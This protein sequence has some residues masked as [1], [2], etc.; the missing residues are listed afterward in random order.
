[1]VDS[2]TTKLVQGAY[3]APPHRVYTRAKWTD[4]WTLR[5]YLYCNWCQSDCS[6]TL[7]R[8]ELRYQYGQILRPG[9]IKYQEFAALDVNR[10]FVKIEIDLPEDDEEEDPQFAK[11]YGRIWDVE[12]EREGIVSGYI[13]GNLKQTPMGSQRFSCLGL[14]YELDRLWLSSSVLD[15]PGDVDK[16]GEVRINRAIDVNRGGGNPW[17]NDL[18][19]LPNRSADIGAKNFYVFSASIPR[20]KLWH[21]DQFLE[22]L[23]AYHTPGEIPWSVDP[24]GQLGF[25]RWWEPALELH[26]LTIRQVIDV[27]VDRRRLSTWFAR[28]HEVE[29]DVDQVKIYVASLTPNNIT[30]DLDGQIL[31]R[32]PYQKSIDFDKSFDVSAV[33][34]HSAIHVVDRVRVVGARRTA[35]FSLNRTTTT[36]SADW[37][38][39]EQE[40]Y[41]R[42]AS[43]RP[44]YAAA[45][46]STKERM[47][48]LARAEPA[49]RRVFSYFLVH[50]Y[51]KGLVNKIGTSGQPKP[52]CPKLDENGEITDQPIEWWQDGM[53]F[54]HYL[55]LKV[56]YDYSQGDVSDP[57]PFE[58]TPDGAESKFMAP[59]AVMEFD[60]GSD[61]EPKREAVLLHKI[62]AQSRDELE[63]DG[64]RK[65]SGSLEIRDNAPGFIIEIASPNQHK[66]G[67]AD[68]EFPEYDNFV[69][70]AL[71]G[72]QEIEP[73]TRWYRDLSITACWK[74]DDYVEA[75]YPKGLDDNVIEQRIELGDEYRLDYL[76][77]YTIVGIK[78]GKLRTCEDGG[79][80]R[81]DRKKLEALGQVAYGWFSRE[82]QALSLNIQQIFGDLVVGDMLIEI[83]SGANKVTV[84]SAVTSVRYDL[85]AVTTTVATDFGELD[86]ASFGERIRRRG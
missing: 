40:L 22:Y 16:F 43:T 69:F 13:D 26:G 6:P 86:L 65:W 3:D 10:H 82:R 64:G 84:N 47:N 49:C 38:Q 56:D 33:H 50:D 8:A 71:S 72:V 45:D 7:P 83:G 54:A 60:T 85:L 14:E 35:T 68:T 58:G 51:W 30:S 9:T 20:A 70:Q 55:P 4:Q 27:L 81:D 66:I 76:A 2:I 63:G 18:H 52:A 23:L 46:V 1:M 15:E 12:F 32:N 34:V 78:E 41:N 67:K 36:L 28:V 74:T 24:D 48:D 61:T 19:A 11:W 29:G 44:E 21:A 53:R 77:P 39:R 57:D 5:P 31:P 62:A 59:F 25:L 75:L 42:A 73:E 80:V 37:T 17:A 79:F